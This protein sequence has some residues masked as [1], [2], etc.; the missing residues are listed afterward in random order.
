MDDIRILECFDD[1]DL[2]DVNACRI[3]LQVTTL[4]DICDGSGRMITEEAW[5][6]K[7]LTDRETTL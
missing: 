5:M 1:E 7:R 6:G 2:Y 3:H 4:S